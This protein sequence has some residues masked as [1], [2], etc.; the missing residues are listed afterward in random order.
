MKNRRAI[1]RRNYSQLLDSGRRRANRLPPD[2]QHQKRHSTHAR[3]RPCFFEL[4]LN[5]IATTHT[6]THS[7]QNSS[8]LRFCVWWSI[9]VDYKNL[10]LGG[11]SP[12]CYTHTY[13]GRPPWAGEARGFDA[14]RKTHSSIFAI[15]EA[16]ELR[17]G[18]AAGWCVRFAALLF[19]FVICDQ[20]SIWCGGSLIELRTGARELTPERCTKADWMEV[21]MP[22][23]HCIGKKCC[24]GVRHSQAVNAPFNW[25][26][27]FYILLW[28]SYNTKHK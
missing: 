16:T 4:I 24:G 9:A 17:R 23:Y 7:T 15:E 1:V 18:G 28:P 11:L 6:H 12:T 21:E 13:G 26:K 2:R 10:N 3:R 8:E 5:S 19:W 14:I 25:N 20:S 22:T 27:I